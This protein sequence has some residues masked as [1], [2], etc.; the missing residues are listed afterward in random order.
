M[1][2]NSKQIYFASANAARGFVSYFKRCFAD[3][4]ISRLYMIKGGPGTG[5]SRF[6]GD[7]A[8]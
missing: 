7:V 8:T 5:K 2:E 6:I 4:R 1:Q 3:A